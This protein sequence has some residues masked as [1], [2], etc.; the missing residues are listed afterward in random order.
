MP[1]AKAERVVVEGKLVADAPPEAVEDGTIRIKGKVS[2]DE[3]ECTLMVSQNLLEGV[4]LVFWVGSRCGW[5]G[6]GGEA[7]GPASRPF[8]IGG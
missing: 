6:A 2:E 5:L 3:S 4:Q 8:G 1:P 7:D